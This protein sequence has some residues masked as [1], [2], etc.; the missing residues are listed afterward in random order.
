LKLGEGALLEL[1]GGLYVRHYCSVDL[2]KGAHVKIGKRCFFNSFSSI[3]VH[4]SM[5]IGDDVICGE[6][7]KFYDNDHLMEGTV[8]HKNKFLTSPITIGPNVWIANNV[9]VLR[10][11]IV[12]ANTVIGAMSLVKSEL[13]GNAVYAG[14]P[15]KK[16]KDLEE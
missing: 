9:N 12:Q 6:S 3:V 2:G 13:Q 14:I 5:E 1:E 8:I 11:S 16:I 4:S 10:G 7:V 15:V